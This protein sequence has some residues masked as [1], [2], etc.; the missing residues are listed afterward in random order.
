VWPLAIP[1]GTHWKEIH[2]VLEQIG[3]LESWPGAGDLR[4][5]IE[6]RVIPA[7]EWATSKEKSPEWSATKSDLSGNLVIEK[8]DE[9]E[10][11][12]LT[13]G[14][15]LEYTEDVVDEIKVAKEIALEVEQ[16]G[17]KITVSAPSLA[18]DFETDQLGSEA[19]LPV[20][21]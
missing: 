6:T 4:D 10:S 1:N 13:S 11:E 19:D 14:I 7:L 5:W 8:H 16:R 20:P 3:G 12:A 21:A 17:R 18:A 9:I 15:A 2:A